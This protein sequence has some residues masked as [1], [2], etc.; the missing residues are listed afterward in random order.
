VQEV[1]VVSLKVFSQSENGANQDQ[2]ARQI[3]NMQ[4]FGPGDVRSTGSWDWVFLNLPVEVACCDDE[5]P[6]EEDL[7]KE[8][9]DNDML[10]SLHAI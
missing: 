4:M 6:E 3:K 7:N 1:S 9:D 5:E 8:A 2:E 10:A